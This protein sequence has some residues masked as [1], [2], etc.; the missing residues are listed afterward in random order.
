MKIAILE[1]GE[2]PEPIRRRYPSYGQMMTHMLAARLPDARFDAVRVFDPSP[3]RIP[4]ADGYLITGSP[5]GVYE[6]HPWI[7][8]LLDT[9]RAIAVAGKPQVGICFG[10]QAMAAA[11]GGDVRKSERGWGVGVHAYEVVAHQ[12]FMEGPSAPA[13]DRITCAVSHQDQVVVAPEGATVIAGSAFCPNGA[14]VYANGPAISFQMHPEFDHTFASDL[15]RLRADRIPADRVSTGL[16]SLRT[17]SD[18]ALIATW[19]AQFLASGIGAPSGAAQ[20]GGHSRKDP[21]P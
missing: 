1:T 16:A 5:A 20:T 7:P 14:L 8:A 6:P 21:C 18:Q 4:D 15:L 11:F 3:A 2:P 10:H 13:P 12:G 19:I 9:V 17:A